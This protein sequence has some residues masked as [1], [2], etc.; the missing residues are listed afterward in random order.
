MRVG[1]EEGE[2][3]GGGEGER[4]TWSL[5]R[6]L[7]LEAD[8]KSWWAR[9]SGGRG[10]RGGQE[11]MEEVDGGTI[12]PNDYPK[13]EDLLPIIKGVFYHIYPTALEQA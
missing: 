2:D 7:E 1:E 5:G 12:I 8:G 4:W 13:L 3:R 6:R 11:E 10:K 9:R